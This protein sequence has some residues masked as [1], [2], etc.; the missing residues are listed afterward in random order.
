MY[1][2]GIIKIEMASPELYI[3]KPLKNAQSI[4]KILNK[5][6]ASFVLFSELCLSGYS[7]GDLFFEISFLDENL[8][9]L[10]FIMDNTS[11]QGVYFVGMPFL[12]QEV[13]F[14]VAVVVQKQKILGIVPKKTIPNYKEF[15]EKRWFQSGKLINKDII[16]FLGQKVPIG[17]I[18]FINKNFD[19]VFGVEICQDLWTINSPSDLLVLNG[20]H[21]IF[22]LSASTEH[23]NKDKFRKLAVLNHSRK[24]ISGYFYTSSGISESSVRSLFSNHKIASVVGEI[25]SEKDLNDPDI[26]LVV[27]I[28]IDY[29]KYQRRIDTTFG[30]Q[31]INKQFPFLES[32]FELKENDDYQLEKSFSQKPFLNNHDLEEQLKLSNTIQVLSLHNRIKS[33]HFFE[34]I[35]EI[36]NRLNDF[37]TLLVVLQY[38][39]KIKKDL[40]LLKIIMKKENYSN[41]YQT[42]DFYLKMLSYLGIYNVQIIEQKEKYNEIFLD[43]LSNKLILE[44]DNL[45]DI[46]S[47]KVDLINQNHYYLYNLNVSIPNTFMVELILFHFRNQTIILEDYIKNFYLLKIDEFLNLQV[48]I[49]DFILYHYLNGGLKKEKIVFLLEKSFSLS[50]EKSLILVTQYMNNFYKNQYKKNKIAPGPQILSNCLTYRK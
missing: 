17:D 35:F 8:S 34:I 16:S 13:L 4:V 46:F 43:N 24:Q 38:F 14:N 21:L 28:L 37:L 26:S 20:A 22:N 40:K 36:K 47:G 50:Y 18:L 30:D 1:K 9:A 32:Y 19:I 10:R 12:F 42:F 2:N 25:V 23:L 7:A 41:N 11:F 31:K 45:S 39:K 48:I 15:N 33:F 3:G 44:S 29:I 27:D 6:K 49:E 5:S